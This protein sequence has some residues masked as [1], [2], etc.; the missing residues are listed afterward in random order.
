[1]C[2]F[3]GRGTMVDDLRQGGTMDWDRDRLK[4][5]VNTPGLVS[6]VLQHPSRDIAGSSRLPWIDRPQRVPHVVFLQC[7]LG[8]LCTAGCG[9]SAFGDPVSKRAK[10]QFSSSASEAPPSAALV[11]AL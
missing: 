9:V 2:C 11:L 5:L 1:M 7:G 10:K 4:I 6:A 3:L 8:L